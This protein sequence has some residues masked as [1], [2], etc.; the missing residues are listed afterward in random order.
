MGVI[1][2][3]H[4]CHQGFLSSKYII[5][6]AA[7]F[8]FTLVCELFLDLTLLEYVYG[9]LFTNPSRFVCPFSYTFSPS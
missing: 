1:P 2:E 3:E 5:Y 8:A 7:E 4:R 6:L 9:L